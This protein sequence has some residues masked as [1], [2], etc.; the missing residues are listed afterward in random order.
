MFAALR[1]LGRIAKIG[2]TLGTIV[3]L[4]LSGYA[5]VSVYARRPG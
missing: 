1:N 5:S 2:W 4:S 3:H